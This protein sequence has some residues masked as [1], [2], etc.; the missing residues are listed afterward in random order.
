MLGVYQ[1]E[2]TKEVPDVLKDVFVPMFEVMLQGEMC[3]L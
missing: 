1:P 3:M 2:T